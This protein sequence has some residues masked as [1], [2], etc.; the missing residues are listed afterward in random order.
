MNR[1]PTEGGRTFSNHISHMRLISKL[2]KN[3]KLNSKN[4]NNP[5]KKIINYICNGSVPVME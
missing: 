2:Y 5:S 4:P 3:T 1:L